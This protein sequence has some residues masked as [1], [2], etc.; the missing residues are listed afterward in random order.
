MKTLTRTFAAFGV[1]L[2]LCGATAA[3]ASESETVSAK[4]ATVSAVNEFGT[5]TSAIDG[6]TVLQLKGS[7]FQA[8]KGGAGGIY[9]VFGWVSDPAGLSWTPSNGGVTGDN[10]RYAP[11]SEDES[12]LGFSR[13]IAFEGSKTASAANGGLVSADGSWE[14][15]LTIPAATFDSFD[16]EGER[17]EVNCLEVTCGVIT[18]GAH[19][20]KNANNE[21]FTPISFVADPA[22]GEDTPIDDDP[23]AT[24]EPAGS[25]DGEA[26]DATTAPAPAE[27]SAAETET[28]GTDATD[29]SENENSET[30]EG[31]LSTTHIVI[32]V[33]TIVLAVAVWAISLAVKRKKA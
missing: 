10:Y 19:N 22:E 6:G 31:G 9:V 11:D 2:A 30:S 27:T 25:Q 8:I 1:A 7:S 29:S 24:S 33:G 20:N 16:R 23:A 17:A 13:F 14:T 4:G 32:I 12:N 28:D 5:G 26:A 21:T 15:E 18:I 3:Y